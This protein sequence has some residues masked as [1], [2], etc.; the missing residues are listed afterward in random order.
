MEMIKNVYHTTEKAIW[1]EQRPEATREEPIS[2]VK[3]E[4]TPSD[5]YDA[6]NVTGDEPISGV[7]GQGT[8][9]DPYDAGNLSPSEP[10]GHSEC[11]VFGPARG[12]FD[13]GISHHS[14]A[15]TSTL[16]DSSP[17]VPQPSGILSSGAADTGSS[18]A[19]TGQAYIPLTEDSKVKSVGSVPR[20]NGPSTL[21]GREPFKTAPSDAPGTGPTEPAGSTHPTSSPTAQ[22]STSPSIKQQ[23][24]GGQRRTSAL[25]LTEAYHNRAGLEGSPSQSSPTASAKRSSADS[26]NEQTNPAKARG[27]GPEQKPV[28]EKVVRSTGFAAEGGNFDASEPGAGKEADRLLEEQQK[29]HPDAAPVKGAML[30]KE[31]STEHH[32]GL[33]TGTH[34]AGI[35]FSKAKDKLHIGKHHDS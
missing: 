11:H 29:R 8:A 14:G 35:S 17:G 21:G 23:D 22:A 16:P 20:G 32:G 34:K 33:W 1:G 19:H 12:S 3:G 4:G 5:P 25:E 26:S 27:G 9:S 13:Q 15:G 30:E 7:Q 10:V 28:E 18:M 24:L 2:G 6:G 31:K